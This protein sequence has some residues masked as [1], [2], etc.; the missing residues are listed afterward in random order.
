MHYFYIIFNFGQQTTTMFY[1]TNMGNPSRDS[2]S[3]YLFL[4]CMD[5]LHGLISKTDTDGDIKGV[6]ISRQGPRLTN[7]KKKKKKKRWQ[8]T[9]LQGY[10]KMVTNFQINV[11]NMKVV[12]TG[13]KIFFFFFLLPQQQIPNSNTQNPQKKRKKSWSCH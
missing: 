6:S 11:L 5:G 12:Y 2:L 1:K 4:L 7:F 3:S 13:K 9:I 10:P 8:C